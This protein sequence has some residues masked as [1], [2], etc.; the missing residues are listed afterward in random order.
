MAAS[1]AGSTQQH[2]C[3]TPRSSFLHGIRPSGHY[4]GKCRVSLVVA[5]IAA[6]D[7]QAFH[8]RCSARHAGIGRIDHRVR[9]EFAV[10]STEGIYAV[11]NHYSRC[12]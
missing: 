10:E 1:N 12:V 4:T 11:A 5:N 8:K 9:K 3:P 7:K 6:N 2:E